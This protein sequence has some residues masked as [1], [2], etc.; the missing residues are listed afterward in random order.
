MRTYDKL[1]AHIHERRSAAGSRARFGV[2]S[3][4][5]LGA[6]VTSPRAVRIPSQHH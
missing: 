6:H 3:Q 2:I 5:Y 1:I 4:R